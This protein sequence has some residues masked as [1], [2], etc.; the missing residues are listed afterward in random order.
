MG[1]FGV[2]ALALRLLTATRDEGGVSAEEEV[3]VL[4]F[5]KFIQ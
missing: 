3:V 2:V 5:C 1:I 4:S